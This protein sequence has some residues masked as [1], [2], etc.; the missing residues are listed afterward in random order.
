MRS[1]LSCTSWTR[2]WTEKQLNICSCFPPLSE[3]VQRALLTTTHQLTSHKTHKLQKFKGFECV[4][5]STETHT[6]ISACA[7]VQTY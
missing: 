4:L 7:Y 5:P 6:G 1:T 2:D 3:N